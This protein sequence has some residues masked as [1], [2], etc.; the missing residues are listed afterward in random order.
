MPPPGGF[1]RD[2]SGMNLTSWASLIQDVAQGM[3]VVPPNLAMEVCLDSMVLLQLLEATTGMSYCR[4]CC[5]PS[6]WCHCIDDYQL[7]P[8]ETWSQMM[9]RM[10]GQGVVASIGGPTTPGT[11]TTEVREQGVPPPP[12]GLHPPDLT[13]WSLPLPEAPLIGALLIP[14]GGLPG[15]G[16]QTVGPWASGQRT[17]APPMQAPS[18][19]QG[20]LPVHQPRLHQPAT[21]YQQAAQPQNQP[22]TLYQQ[23]VQPQSQPATSYEQAVQP[24]SQPATPYQQAVQPP[25]RPTGRGLLA[26]PTSDRAAPAADRTIPERGRQQARGRGIRGRS[27]SHPG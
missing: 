26:Q 13:N 15:I 12:P 8:M 9:A 7:S 14:S 25:R 3:K 20:T 27:V 24:S 22:A 21:P 23:A 2:L 16:S 18:A 11:V 4:I 10:P 6:P 5:Q 19:P 1:P 17:P